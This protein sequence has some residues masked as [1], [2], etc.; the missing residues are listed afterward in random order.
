MV[1][2]TAHQTERTDTAW[3]SR[4]LRHPARKRSGYSY[5]PGVCTGP[6]AEKR[7]TRSVRLPLR[8]RYNIT[9]T[10][11]LWRVDGTDHP[12]A[13]CGSYLLT[14]SGTYVVSATGE[15]LI[16]YRWKNAAY[17]YTAP[18]RCSAASPFFSC[19]FAQL[20]LFVV[21]S[22]TQLVIYSVPGRLSNNARCAAEMAVT[23]CGPSGEYLRPKV[24]IY[25][26][27]R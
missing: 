21:C 14:C 13:R 16:M 27:P 7:L 11:R 4:L 25:E 5:N 1:I 19:L 26:S 18:V 6:T 12:T 24:I 9:C 3:L 2:V 23:I 15:W 8:N 17:V 10:D 20:N 22:D